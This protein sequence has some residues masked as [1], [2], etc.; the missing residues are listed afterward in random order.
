MSTGRLRIYNCQC[1]KEFLIH[2]R[3]LLLTDTQQ[4]NSAKMTSS[5]SSLEVI[6]YNLNGYTVLEILGEGHFGKVAKCFKGE[7]SEV[8]AVKILKDSRNSDLEQEASVLRKLSLIKP[9]E[10]N[11]VRF[12][13]FFKHDNYQCMVFEML[14]RSLLDLMIKRQ[15]AF[16]LSEIRPI[17]QQLL[18][19]F[20]A[21]KSIGMIHRDLKSDN[22]MLVN[23]N[24]QPLKVKLIDFGLA[25]HRS[26]LSPD[27]IL[28]PLEFR[29]PEFTLGLP[30]SEAVDMWSLGCCLGLWYLGYNIFA[31]S[32]EYDNISSI[33]HLLGQPSDD[34][35][36]TGAFTKEYFVETNATP[37]W[38][39]KTPQEYID[40]TGNWYNVT[41]HLLDGVPNLD[42]AVKNN[43]SPNGFPEERDRLAFLSLLKNLLHL[44]PDKRITPS[45]ALQHPFIKMEYLLENQTYYAQW[46]RNVMN[47]TLKDFT[48]GCAPQDKNREEDLEKEN[49]RN[50]ASFNDRDQPAPQPPGSTPVS[51]TD[52]NLANGDCGSRPKVKVP[53]PPDVPDTKCDDSGSPQ[54]E[55]TDIDVEDL[56]RLKPGEQQEEST[57]QI[58][59]VP[60]VIEI[61]TQTGVRVCINQCKDKQER[62]T[63]EHKSV[64]CSIEGNN[65]IEVS[66]CI[67][68]R[69][70]KPKRATVQQE[71]VPR[72]PGSD[73]Q[74][75]VGTCV[76]QP[77][78][79]QQEA[80]VEQEHVPCL[81][82]PD[83]QIE[84]DSIHD[85]SWG[86]E[87]RATHVASTTAG[88]SEHNSQ[89]AVPPSP[90]SETWITDAA[91]AVQALLFAVFCG[92]Y[93]LVATVLFA[94]GYIDSLILKPHSPNHDPH[95]ASRTTPATTRR[96]P[97]S[98]SR[99]R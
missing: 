51:A 73:N 23:H 16:Q 22:I 31:G 32:S 78:N 74:T 14:D 10:S 12:I 38:R 42:D 39:L 43:E 28:Q 19:A 1:F 76:S 13:D 84:A 79:K 5:S 26:E 77:R 62:T 35:L 67:N 15:S 95:T 93:I 44:D 61:D 49:G 96:P 2:R 24:V 17:T 69:R 97:G 66:I 68:Q 11:I 29:A 34:L 82:E 47:L 87:E 90:S 37:Q 80:I 89:T 56:V 59:Y 92:C 71:N 21:L 88:S 75:E 40:S 83:N 3:D 25:T 86:E 94:L 57:I 8:V 36:N 55:C 46:A 9:D 63:V 70:D 6:P 91:S 52:S 54:N 50:E 64:S 30:L 53:N 45:E 65:R 18:V 58:K 72:S 98:T 4:H 7:T 48:P 60:G 33:V 99:G 41:E 85:Q 27:M 81:T 20:E